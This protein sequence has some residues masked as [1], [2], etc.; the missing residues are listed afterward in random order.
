MVCRLLFSVGSVQS[1]IQFSVGFRVY[2]FQCQF[3]VCSVQGTCVLFSGSFSV[4]TLHCLQ[5]SEHWLF[6]KSL[7]RSESTP[8]R[9]SAPAQFLNF[10]I[11]STTEGHLRTKCNA[12]FNSL[13]VFS[14]VFSFQWGSESIAFSVSSVS[15]A[16]RVRVYCLVG[17]SPS[18]LFIVCSVQSTGCL[19]RVCH[20]QSPHPEGP[21]PLRSSWILTSRQPQR[22]TW[23]QNTMQFLIHFLSLY[24]CTMT[25]VLVRIF[26]RYSLV[27]PTCQL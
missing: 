8:W 18:V 16:F 14:L 15:V 20:V 9:S 7:S 5:C 25:H 24:Q 19:P 27:E 23:G 12:I 10:N 22:V 17:H 1:S 21:L 4:C 11:P 2:S 13:F 3:S 6:T 26:G